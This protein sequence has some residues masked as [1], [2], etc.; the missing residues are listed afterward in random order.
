VGH[1]VAFIVALWAMARL[2]ASRPLLRVH[3]RLVIVS[4]AL[5]L[6]LAVPSS[7][8]GTAF[9]DWRFPVMAAFAAVAALRPDG[10]F[11][12]GCRWARSMLSRQPS[13][14]HPTPARR[15]GTA[16]L[17]PSGSGASMADWP[18]VT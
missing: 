8:G 16:E 10:P 3:V 4:L 13:A 17:P 7:L 18:I 6:G 1:D 2:V 11:L 12:V 15:R 5:V 9:V 14:D